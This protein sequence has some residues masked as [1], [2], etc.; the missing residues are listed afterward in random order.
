MEELNLANGPRYRVPFR[1]RRE[2]KTNYHRRLKLIKSGK[3]RLVIRCSNKHCTAQVVKSLI[4]GDKILAQSHSQHLIKEYDWK[5]NTGNV[6]ASYLT[7]YLCGLRAKNAGIDEAILDV[8]ILVHNERVKSAF[9]GF[10][11]SGIHV[12]HG[13]NWFPESLE[14]RINGS[15]IEQFAEALSKDNPERYEVQFSK[16]LRNKGDPTK[17]TKNF[18]KVKKK[19]EKA[20]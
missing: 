3:D 16:T 18:N 4:E 13:E 17:F 5:F 20:V 9:K 10:L 6:P 19:M 8:G 12:N 2:G 15:H 1:R 14:D 11:D 7:G